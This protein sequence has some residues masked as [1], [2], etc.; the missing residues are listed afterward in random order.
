MPIIQSM[1][2]SMHAMLRGAPLVRVNHSEPRAPG[3][4]PDVFRSNRHRGFVGHRSLCDV[5]R[6]AE[7]RHGT[8]WPW[9]KRCPKVKNECGLFFSKN[10]NWIA[11]TYII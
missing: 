2:C 1:P 11:K 6:A 5:L 3:G 8:P 9:W 10:L 7:H 4:L